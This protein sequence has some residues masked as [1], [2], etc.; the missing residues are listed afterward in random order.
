MSLPARY[1]ASR[2][3]IDCLLTF[4]IGV[5]VLSVAPAAE[6]AAATPEAR[7]ALLIGNSGY[8]H[9]PLINPRNDAR[10]LAKVLDSLGFEVEVLIDS[11]KEKMTEAIFEFGDRLRKRGGVGFFYYAGHGM[12]VGGEN[13]L[14]PVGAE[15]PSERYVK[16][17]GV[18]MGEVTTGLAN[19]RNKMNIV[20]LDAC[21]N[22]PF[23][24][25]WRSSSRGLAV[26]SAPAETLIAYATEP[27]NVASDGSGTRNSPYAEA[28]IDSIQEPGI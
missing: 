17:R 19:A 1:A 2:H 28:L 8:T 15:I 16:L 23:A 21:R 10:D 3:L 27:G 25:S 4:V 22:N 24:R 11:N 18:P 14:I 26:M 6:V 13:Y 9:S 12:E 20:V 7:T 5:A